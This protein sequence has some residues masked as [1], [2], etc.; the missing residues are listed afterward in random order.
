MS[1]IG[2]KIVESLKHWFHTLETDLAEHF[3]D[4]ETILIV[5]KDHMKNQ[6]YSIE[7]SECGEDMIVEHREVDLD[8]DL[9]LIVQPCG[10]CIDLAR[11][12]GMNTLDGLV[13][14]NPKED[15]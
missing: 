6:P 9:Y 14:S 5:N 10:N 13:V 8:N 1:D 11:V 2:D 3:E 15:C 12:S 7:C 4:D